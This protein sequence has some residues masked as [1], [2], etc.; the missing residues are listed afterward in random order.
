M[1]VDHTPDSDPSLYFED[2]EPGMVLTSQGRTVTETDLVT[3]CMLSGDWNPIHS[4]EEFSQHTDYGRRVVHGVFGISLLTGLMDRAG[5]FARSAV[6]MLGIK[7]W[8]FAGP[9]FVG[10]TLHCE[11][12]IT[13]LRL[14]SRGDRAVVGRHFRLINQR[15]E[16]VQEGQ[17]PMMVL[18]RGGDLR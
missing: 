16:V 8:R 11:L 2:L 1:S 17:I 5:W 10:D 18:A 12:E 14:T 13:D 15:Q 3:F 4:D 6:A 7:D 9:I